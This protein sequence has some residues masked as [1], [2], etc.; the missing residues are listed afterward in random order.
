MQ[1]QQHRIDRLTLRKRA[2]QMPGYCVLGITR[3]L[4]RW[5]GI[6]DHAG[7]RRPSIAITSSQKTANL[8]IGSGIRGHDFVIKMYC[9]C[10][11]GRE[12]GW[13]GRESIGLV[14]E[15][16]DKNTTC[17]WNAPGGVGVERWHTW[18]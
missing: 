12:V 5:R 1:L 8:G 10:P 15:T 6:G 13:Q 18:R 4:T 16:S 14:L 2:Q 7:Y 11:I 9:P 17:Q 3:D